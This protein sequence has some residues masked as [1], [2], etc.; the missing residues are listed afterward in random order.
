MIA[1]QSEIEEVYPHLQDKFGGNLGEFFLD[2]TDA[3]NK[4]LI[5]IEDVVIRNCTDAFLTQ[6]NE[7]F[8]SE[9]QY[10]KVILM[11]GLDKLITDFVKVAQEQEDTN[12]NLISNRYNVLVIV[13]VVIRVI[14]GLMFG[15]YY[16]KL[17][18]LDDKVKVGSIRKTIRDAK[19]EKARQTVLVEKLAAVKASR[20][21]AEN[22]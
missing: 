19:R 21:S 9:Y 18:W 17:N 14:A 22:P 5:E 10:K 11:H 1:R 4:R 12:M 20:Q 2:T 7:L 3:A 15:Y 13:L 8:S 16:A 6:N